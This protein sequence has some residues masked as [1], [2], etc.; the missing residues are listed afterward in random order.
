MFCLRC[1]NA[2]LLFRGTYALTVDRVNWMCPSDVKPLR[3]TM[4]DEVPTPHRDLHPVP[5][6]RRPVKTELDKR[7]IR[8]TIPADHACAGIASERAALARLFGKD[9]TR[10]SVPVIV[11]LVDSR[12][13]QMT[14][15]GMGEE[16]HGPCNYQG[17]IGT[18]ITRS[19]T[20]PDDVCARHKRICGPGMGGL[21]FNR[22]RAETGEQR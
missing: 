9:E 1:G 17:R 13:Q 20:D 16:H 2:C 7:I 14:P 10:V 15:Q 18:R 6:I 22:T 11:I 5:R 3:F 8:I 4:A 19:L 21:P 12:R